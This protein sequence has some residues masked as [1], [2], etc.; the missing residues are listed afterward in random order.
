MYVVLWS[1]VYTQL[2]TSLG[3]IYLP[4]PNCTKYRDIIH[5]YPN[6]HMYAD[7]IPAMYPWPVHTRTRTYK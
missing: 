7:I 6:V 5:N 4:Q 1:T 3:K 2:M